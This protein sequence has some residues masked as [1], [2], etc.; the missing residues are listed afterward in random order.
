MRQKIT[1]SLVERLLPGQTVTDRGPVVDVRKTIALISERAEVNFMM[2]DLRR[3]FATHC[4]ALGISYFDIKRLL[5]HK[6]D[7]REA[8]PGYIVVEL[9]RKKDQVTRLE[10]SLMTLGGITLEASNDQGLANNASR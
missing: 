2:S 3:T 1:K 6:L 7:N 4:A 9:E 10:E 5:N 8:T